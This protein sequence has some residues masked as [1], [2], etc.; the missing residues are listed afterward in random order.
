MASKGVSA[1]Q[2]T[3]KRKT[4][5]PEPDTESL[6]PQ[7]RNRLQ[8]QG[9][10]KIKD[11][12]ALGATSSIRQ[13]ELI[14][15]LARVGFE[16]IKGGIRLNLRSQIQAVIRERSYVNPK[17]L[18]QLVQ[19]AT[20][21]EVKALGAQMVKEGGLRWALRGKVEY[22]CDASVDLL[23]VAELR[24]LKA[25]GEVAGKLLK[26]AQPKS[27]LRSDVREE[28]LDVLEHQRAKTTPKRDLHTQMLE[29]IRRLSPKHRGLC[30]VPDLVR[31]LGKDWSLA[32]IHASLLQAA[33]NRQIELQM[34]A[35]VNLLKEEEQALCPKETYY[36]RPLSWARIL[37]EKQP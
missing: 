21:T 4:K 23:E 25:M 3:S 31:A 13:T 6:L 35:G 16:P 2:S 33:K 30:F 17:E 27:L 20:Q 12:K 18:G 14:A 24:K 1:Q 34:D 7:A 26:A 11:L 15:I 36:G 10:L 19:G 32:E 29:E 9:V 5:V 8:A 37:E 28:L 22:L